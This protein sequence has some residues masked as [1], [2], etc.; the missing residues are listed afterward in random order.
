M[1]GFCRIGIPGFGLVAKPLFEAIRGPDTETLLWNGKQEKA[2]CNNKQ[3][4]TGA[5]TLGLANLNKPFFLQVAE[6]QGQLWGLGQ[7]LGEVPQPI[8]YFS[9]QLD[10]MTKAG[11]T[12]FKQ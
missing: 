8:G 1:A 7:Q 6:K 5:L 11:L 3:A 10:S 4:L 9:K 12:T 2:F